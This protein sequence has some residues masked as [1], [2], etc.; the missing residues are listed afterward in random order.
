MVTGGLVR[1]VADLYELDRSQLVA[2]ERMG[3]KSADNLLAA[4]DRSKATTLSRLLY[5]L[6]IADVGEAT[7]QTLARHFGT[8][9]ALMQADLGQLQ[10]VP[11]VG[12]VVAANIVAFFAEPRNRAI[13]KR[14]ERAGVHWVEAPAIRATAGPLAGR[15]YVLTGTLSAMSRDAAKARLQALGARVAGTVSRRTSAVIAGAE[16]GSKLDRAR[17][18]GVEVLDEPAFVALLAHYRAGTGT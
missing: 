12:P 8:L 10:S 5:A 18:L 4:I 17:E 9:Q 11:D 15:T 1:D 14:L 13:V 6:G 3:E 7:A 2:L 16:P